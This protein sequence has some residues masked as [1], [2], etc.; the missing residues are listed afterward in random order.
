MKVRVLMLAFLLCVLCITSA[1]ALNLDGG[2]EIYVSN[3]VMANETTQDGN[4]DNA[5]GILSGFTVGKVKFKSLD[6]FTFSFGKYS[7]ERKIIAPNGEQIAMLGNINPKTSNSFADWTYTDTWKVTFSVPG[8][9]YYQI[10]VEGQKL[11]EF[12]FYVYNR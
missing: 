3:H 4:I 9:Y 7:I 2:R 5:K 1:F 12:P 10:N 8:I 6:A 11:A